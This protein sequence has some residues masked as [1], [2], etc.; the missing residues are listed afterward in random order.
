MGAFL[1]GAGE[2]GRGFGDPSLVQKL[3]DQQQKRALNSS[4]FNLKISLEFD[5]NSK[6]FNSE[7]PV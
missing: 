5:H 4:L 3:Q 6:L 7:P 1:E 2:F